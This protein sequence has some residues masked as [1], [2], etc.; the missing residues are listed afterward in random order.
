MAGRFCSELE[1]AREKGSSLANGVLAAFRL[2]LL[3]CVLL[4][5]IAFAADA[6]DQWRRE[7]GETRTLAENDAP[8]AYEQ[9]LRLQAALPADATPVD[10][11]RLLNLLSRIEVYL[12]MTEQA[13]NHAR[14][15]S[16]L[17]AQHGDRVGQAEADLNVALNAVNEG[18]IDAMIAA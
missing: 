9:A 11:A 1:R 8:R 10:Q 4:P 3:A 17:A 2:V 16:D 15:A 14:H 5:G 7:A 6:L 12:A 13:A 18:K